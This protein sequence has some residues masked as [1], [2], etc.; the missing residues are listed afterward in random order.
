MKNSKMDDAELKEAFRANSKKALDTLLAIIKDPEHEQRVQAC[1]VV[2]NRGHGLPPASNAESFMM[3]YLAGEITAVQCGL[4][5]ESQ[6]LHI[7][8]LLESEIKN[9]QN[10]PKRKTTSK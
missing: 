7:G 10:K 3:R 9:E 6:K 1:E 5:M 2:L 8:D 4:L